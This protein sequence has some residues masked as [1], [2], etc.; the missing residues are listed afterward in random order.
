[1][2]ATAGATPPSRAEAPPAATPPAVADTHQERLP[3]ADRWQV[4]GQIDRPEPK[5][6]LALAFAESGSR[7]PA[8]EVRS[9]E[10][11]MFF[12]ELGCHFPQFPFIAHSR[13]WSAEDMEN[14]ITYVQKSD[15]LKQGAEG[16]ADRSIE[17]AKQILSENEP[18]T[19]TVRGG[20]KANPI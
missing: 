1:M 14:N 9:D 3:S 2:G 7:R 8:V 15:E 13:G 18:C 19:K 16:L 10:D 4:T 6:T 5:G 20:R 17:L 12:A 11:G